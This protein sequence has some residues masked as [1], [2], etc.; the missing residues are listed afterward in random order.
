M[1]LSRHIARSTVWPV[2]V[3]AGLVALYLAWWIGRASF[4]SDHNVMDGPVEVSVS[5][6]HHQFYLEDGAFRGDTSLLWD[7][8][9]SND[10]LD[11]LP[12]LIA[13]GTARYGGDI[14]VVIEVVSTRPAD[15]A[16]DHWDHVVECSI[17]VRSGRLALT[18][19][20][21]TGRHR[22]TL[23]GGTYGALMYYGGLDT[24]IGDYEGSDHYRIVL[25]PGP[26]A[27]PRVLRRW[28][29]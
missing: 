10:R 27:P 6:D 24:V 25:W 5:A 16:L 14:P 12:G 17:E 21:D 28:P 3:V 15:L 23:P 9:T 8:E 1:R 11:V 18:S 2:G 19:P 4:G 20:D 26:P 29:R 13:V 22:I 7:E